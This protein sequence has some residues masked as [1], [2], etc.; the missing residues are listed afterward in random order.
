MNWDK[1]TRK[2]NNKPLVLIKM[3]FTKKR[4][5][6]P[7]LQDAINVGVTDLTKKSYSRKKR[8]LKK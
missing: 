3:L 6:K 2:L 1:N 8:I 5:F 4:L 7:E